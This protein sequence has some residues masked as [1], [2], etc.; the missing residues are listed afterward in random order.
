MLHSA[1]IRWY[2]DGPLP[3]EVLSWFAGGQTLEPEVRSD[4]YLVFPECETVGVKLREGKLE[5]KGLVD[6]PRELTTAF[7]VTGRADRWVKWSFGSDGL[8]ALEAELHQSGT[9]VEVHK[10]RYLR[11]FSAD[12]GTPAEVRPQAK[13]FPRAGCNVELTRVRLDDD[14]RAWFSLGF[15][16]FGPADGVAATLQAVLPV[17]LEANGG[18]PGIPLGTHNSLSYPAWLASRAS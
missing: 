2:A 16:A 12:Q 5:I 7:G 18:A 11:K 3:G 1:E 6:P 4:S 10:E 8:R 9:W 14:P 17:F 13:P 15:E